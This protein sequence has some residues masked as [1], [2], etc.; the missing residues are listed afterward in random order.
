MSSLS[1]WFTTFFP[2]FDAGPSASNDELLV[3]AVLS[4]FSLGVISLVIQQ[5]DHLF[6]KL[7]DLTDKLTDKSVKDADKKD[8]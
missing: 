4:C 6:K 1:G 7:G 3:R 8:E 2:I 5:L